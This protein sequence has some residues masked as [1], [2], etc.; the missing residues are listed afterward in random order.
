MLLTPL[1]LG[2]VK[3]TFFCSREKD[4]EGKEGCYFKIFVGPGHLEFL[5]TVA[6]I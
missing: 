6:R 4:G 5:L 1:G 2:N 3:S